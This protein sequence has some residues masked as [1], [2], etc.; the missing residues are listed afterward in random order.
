MKIGITGQSGFIGKHLEQFILSNGISIVPFS[1]SF[2]KS[3]DFLDN[4]IND[5]DIVFHLAFKIKG[6]DHEVIEENL[7]VTQKLMDSISKTKN[8]KIIYASSTQ[9]NNGTTYGNIK[10]EVRKR[11]EKCVNSSGSS[12]CSVLIPNVYGQFARPFYN[13]SIATFCYQCSKG[14]KFV[15]KK[16]KELNLVYVLDVVNILFDSIKLNSSRCIK[17]EDTCNVRVS[18]IIK[19]IESFKKTYNDIKNIPK[20]SNKFEFLLFNTYMSY[21]DVF[22]FIK[23]DITYSESKYRSMDFCLSKDKIRRIFFMDGAH[24]NVKNFIQNYEYNISKS[25]LINLP[26]LYELTSNSY[27]NII[28]EMHYD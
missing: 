9:E 11:L 7:E 24:I 18:E 3:C 19:I 8:K 23:F 22:D 28:E 20:F 26:M 10:Y 13:S 15:L 6:T 14:E 25:F 2:F 21:M 16:D 1:K 17:I 12:I 27:G 4:F 5:C